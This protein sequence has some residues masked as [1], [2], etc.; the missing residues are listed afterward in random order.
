MPGLVLPGMTVLYYPSCTTLGT[1]SMPHAHSVLDS[2][3]AVYPELKVVVG[4]YF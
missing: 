2:R 1:P 4:L 3:A